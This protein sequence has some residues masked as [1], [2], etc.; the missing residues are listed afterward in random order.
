MHLLLYYSLQL[1]TKCWQVPW[2]PC[3]TF[4]QGLWM[5]SLSPSIYRRHCLKRP[6]ISKTHTT[7]LTL[8][9]LLPPGR[10]HR[11]P[12]TT[13]SKGIASS[14]QPAL[15]HWITRTT[16][17]PKQLK[18]IMDCFCCTTDCSFVLLWS[19]YRVLLIINLIIEFEIVYWCY[20][21]NGHV[22]QS[23]IKMSL[24]CCMYI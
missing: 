24:F 12:K 18:S 4:S 10:W 1:L 8:I 20:Y 16:T 11:N 9:S 21:I 15:E 23:Q 2:M 19:G 5:T 14:Q 7:L 6:A 22:K 3:H 17:L 13:T